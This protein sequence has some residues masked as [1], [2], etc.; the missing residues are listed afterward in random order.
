MTVLAGTLGAVRAPWPGPGPPAPPE[1]GLT[2]VLD[3]VQQLLPRCHH[4][5]AVLRDR[6][7]QEY[8]RVRAANVNFAMQ[9][10]VTPAQ[11]FPVFRD[12]FKKNPV[13]TA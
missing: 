2:Q 12:L 1:P 10:I 4:D 11:I 13:G 3:R 7:A 9:K 5:R 8:T 6:F